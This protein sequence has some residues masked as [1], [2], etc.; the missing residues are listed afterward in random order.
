MAKGQN[1]LEDIFT[2]GSDQIDQGYTINAQHVSQSVVALTGEENYDI[3]ISGSLTISGSVYQENPT[4]APSP[5]AAVHNIIVRSAATGEYMLWDNA[6][7]NTSGSS[8][9]SGTS[10]ASGTSGSSG[11]SGSSGTSGISGVDGTSG[12]SGSSGSSGTSGSSGSSGTSGSSGSSGTSGSS[13]SSGT[14]GNG[15]GTFSSTTSAAADANFPDPSDGTAKTAAGYISVVIGAT[16][17]Y[18]PAYTV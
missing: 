17:Y 1:I 8:G 9:S 14:S 13:G 6:E 4:D 10:G 12:T 18:I 15:V 5:L 11:S 7:D 3:S 2:S 16:T